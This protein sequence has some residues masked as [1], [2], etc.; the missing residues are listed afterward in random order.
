LF[1]IDRNL[2][3][4][5]AARYINVETETAEAGAAGES[6]DAAASAVA[7][8]REEMLAKVRAE[9]LAEVRAETQAEALSKAQ[10]ILDEAEADAKQ[11][12]AK[13]IDEAKN[14]AAQLLVDAREE[15][16]DT[17]HQAWRDGFTDGSE[18]GRRSF[19]SR[20]QEKIRED[21][22]KLKRVLDELYTERD[23]TFS[24]LEEHVVG[25]A[26]EIVKKVYNPA[27]EE[28]GSVFLSLIKNALRQMSLDGKIVIR[29]GPAEYERF[30]SS[31]NAFFEL[32]RG[33]TVTASVVRD[34]S[35]S[36]GDCI[37]DT[38]DTTV[39]AGLDS[40]LKYIHLAFEKAES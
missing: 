6:P 19:D 8:M 35:L 36:E 10:E 17:L 39:N 12:A 7:L 23:S 20:L 4:L 31:G 34:V 13:V 14:E 5:G 28:L 37:I 3:K 1:R 29:V 26:I 11:K 9:V 16:D 33:V 18:E 24:G 22:E 32:D 15:A 30:F 2:V 25:L 27:E 38:D 40:Q 21:D